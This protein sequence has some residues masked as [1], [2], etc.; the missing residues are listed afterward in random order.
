MFDDTMGLQGFKF[1]MQTGTVL[2]SF[3][4]LYSVVSIVT[5]T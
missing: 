1:I 2:T 4:D 5:V 3:V